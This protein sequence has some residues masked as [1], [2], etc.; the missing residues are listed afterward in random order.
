MK[1]IRIERTKRGYPAYWEA[2][3]GFTNT[4]EATIIANKDGQPKEAIYVRRR[5]QLANSNHALVILEVG[6]YIVEADHHR[7]DFEIGIYKVIDFD[8]KTGSYITTGK[9]LDRMTIDQFAE[10]YGE[11]EKY[12]KLSGFYEMYKIDEKIA[13]SFRSADVDQVE[14]LELKEE[15]YER[16]FAIT[17]Q[18]NYF[19]WGEWDEEL[20]AFL[21]PAVQAAMEKATCYHCREPHFIEHSSNN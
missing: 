10:K 19:S 21:E 14:I 16:T 4:G 2:G 1:K 6:D 3:G 17:E 8:F 7:E 20:P 9:T 13:A 18:V 12:E 11:L 15:A 5:G